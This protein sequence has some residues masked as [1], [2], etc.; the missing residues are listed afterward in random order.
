MNS[1]SKYT[2]KCKIDQTKDERNIQKGVY[3]SLIWQ[4]K[5]GDP[6]K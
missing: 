1:Y 4:S 5:A 3:L 6:D 2:S